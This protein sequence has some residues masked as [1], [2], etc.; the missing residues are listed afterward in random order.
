MGTK[1]IEIYE[2]F[3]SAVTDDRFAVM[4]EEE[5]MTDLLPLLKRSIYYLCRIAKETEHRVLPGYDLHARNDEE[6]YF[7]QSLSD[8]EI[9]CLAWGMVVSWTE[10]Q[11]NSTSIVRGSII[12]SSSAG[13]S[14]TKSTSTGRTSQ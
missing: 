12:S 11:L 7:E 3:L 5:L 4:S 14:I 13:C 9:E 2:S 1:Y 10:Q 6:G 8:H